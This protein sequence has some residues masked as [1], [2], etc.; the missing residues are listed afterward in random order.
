M[1]NA[2]FI[3]IFSLFIFEAQEKITTGLIVE[4]DVHYNTFS[5]RIKNSFLAIYN[6]NHANYIELPNHRLVSNKKDDLEETT[7]NYEANGVYKQVKTDLNNNSIQSTEQILM[8][9]SVFET[10]EDIYKIKWNLNSL[11]TKKIAGYLCNRAEGFFRGRNYIVWYTIELPLS[12]GPWKLNGLPGLILEAYD[13][14]LKYRWVAKRIKKID[15]SFLKI[16]KNVKFNES[17]S[18]KEFINKKDDTNYRIKN[19]Y[20]KIKTKLPR[21]ANVEIKINPNRQGKELIFEWEQL[22]EEK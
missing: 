18:L 22:V 5:P 21:G 6:A 3:L 16:S 15:D 12:F 11:V 14:T 7:I 20:K 9:E 17:L 4:Y 8:N 13:E 10:K 2:L 1:K 19:A